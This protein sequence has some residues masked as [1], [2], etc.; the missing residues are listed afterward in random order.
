[1]RRRTLD[2]VSGSIV[3]SKRANKVSL[4]NITFQLKITLVPV[5]RTNLMT[6]VSDEFLVMVAQ[7]GGHWAYLELCERHQRL[8]LQ[9][10][11]RITKNSH[12]TED[13][14]QDALMKAFVHIRT[15][16]GRSAFSTWLTRIAIN[17]ALMLLRK[18][19]RH[20]E[21]S[22]E[23]HRDTHRKGL[24]EIV[25]PA[26]NPEEHYIRIERQLRVRQAIRRLSPTLR[27]VAEIRQ[28][29]DGSI[30]EIAM[31]AGLSVAATKSRLSRARLALR[32]SLEGS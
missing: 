4:S 20:Q 9:V 6:T 26:H 22:L 16:D 18:R 31:I 17:S 14:I 1:M 27:K 21:D 30:K 15:F 32:Q 5:E 23:D 8:V 25:E 28:S 11:H 29:Q 2:N 24:L 10:V 12:D 13:V 3:S 7:N 19:R